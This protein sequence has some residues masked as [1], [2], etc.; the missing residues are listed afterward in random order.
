MKKYKRKM[1]MKS[2]NV[3]K[4]APLN[5][6]Y[7]IMLQLRNALPLHFSHLFHFNSLYCIAHTIHLIHVLLF[8][9]TFRSALLFWRADCCPL[10]GR[11]TCCCASTTSMCAALIFST[12]NKYTA[13]HDPASPQTHTYMQT[14]RHTCV[15]AHHPLLY[16]CVCVQFGDQD[17]CWLIMCVVQHRK[18]CQRGAPRNTYEH[19]SALPCMHPPYWVRCGRTLQHYRRCCCTHSCI[20]LLLSHLLCSLNFI[21]TFCIENFN[22]L[23]F[24]NPF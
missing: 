14:Y 17:G 3:G 5:S 9:H 15:P 24:F 4:N 6:Y 21:I 11:I 1:H 23:I 12:G 22:S 8:P 10:N 20:Y 16:T 18:Q 19:T 13:I 7:L 2:A